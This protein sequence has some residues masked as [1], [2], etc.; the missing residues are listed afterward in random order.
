M[1]TDLMKKIAFTLFSF[2]ITLMV[3]AQAKPFYSQYI[4]NNFILNPAVTGIENYTDIK[5]SHRNQWVGINGAPVTSY[6]SI[7]GAIN[8]TDY[9]TTAT[10]FEI[11]GENPRGKQYQENYKA[12]NPHHG[13]GF[14]AINDQ[15]GFVNRLSVYGSY[16]YHQPLSVKTTLSAGFTAGIS[17]VSM[18]KTK[19]DFADLDPNDPAIGYNNGEL[20]TFKP[21]VGVGLWLY[22]AN[23]FAGISVLNIIP[24]KAA[25]VSNNKYG[26]SFS[27]NYFITAGYRFALSEEVSALP[28]VMLQM[29]QPQLYGV[30]ANIKLQYLDKFW[31]GGSYRFSDLVAGYS[32]MAGVNISNTFNLGYA[33]ENSSNTRISSYTKN[34]HEFILGFILGNTYGDSCP[35]NVW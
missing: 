6:I 32:A 30:H 3:M 22:G 10:S 17:S 9:K 15:T 1:H 16:A 8:K 12:P 34:S 7:H 18:D 11:P 23:Y 20:K 24:G 28:S 2:F 14:I 13:L 21:E 27:P 33:Y 31:V 35:R 25:F 4:L 19:I 29:W 5:L 26:S